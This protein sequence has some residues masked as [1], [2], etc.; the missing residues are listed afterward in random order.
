MDESPKEKVISYLKTLP[1]PD[2]ESLACCGESLT[3]NQAI[4][5]VRNETRIGVELLRMF[6]G[7]LED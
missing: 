2:N 5:H 7:R 6:S 3:P 4:E 1:G